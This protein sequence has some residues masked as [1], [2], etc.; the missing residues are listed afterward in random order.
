MSPEGLLD[1]EVFISQLHRR[2]KILNYEFQVES[3]CRLVCLLNRVCL[4]TTRVSSSSNH[5]DTI[6]YNQK[7]IVGNINF[8]APVIIC[9]V[10][11]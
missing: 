3:V 8:K 10:K 4:L 5:G 7:S 6:I 9:D 1:E 2:A 11:I